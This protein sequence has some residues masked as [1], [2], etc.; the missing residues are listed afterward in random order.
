MDQEIQNQSQIEIENENENEN[1]SQQMS[2]IQRQDPESNL[3]S[4]LNLNKNDSTLQSNTNPAKNN[5]NNN[6]TQQNKQKRRT[7]NDNNDR[8]Y[9]CGCGKSYLSYPALYTHL[10]QKH[11]GKPPEGTVL[12]QNIQKQAAVKGNKSDLIENI[13]SYEAKFINPY[14]A[15][16]LDEFLQ[17]LDTINPS[18]RKDK[19]L[20]QYDNTDPIYVTLKKIW[21]E[22]YNFD[23]FKNEEIS[24]IIQW[25]TLY[26]HI[27]EQLDEYIDQE[28]KKNSEEKKD[29][30]TNQE[31]EKDIIKE[32][33]KKQE[34]SETQ[35]QIKNEQQEQ[36]NQA[37]LNKLQELKEEPVN[38]I[39]SKYLI[40]LSKILSQAGMIEMIFFF[41]LVRKNLNEQG[42]LAIGEEHNF[43]MQSSMLKSQISESN[44]T[45]QQNQNK[46]EF[47][48]QN[49]GDNIVIICNDF[50]IEL[51]PN[52]LR[53]ELAD[54]QVYSFQIIGFQEKKITNAIFCFHYF[55]DW[56]FINKYTNTKLIFK[57][58]ADKNE[59]QQEQQ[60]KQLNK[61]NQ[62][63]TDL[64]SSQIN[65]KSNYMQQKEESESQLQ[66]E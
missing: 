41:C 24:N 57:I 56:L 18:F 23:I 34:P 10:K 44:V 61:Q 55:A 60:S 54:E 40:E 64:Q 25:K 38:K 26:Q 46:P 9:Y 4:N 45:N 2:Q 27:L 5:T 59:L 7:R 12:P 51:L 50:L 20:D 8:N 16:I 43:D 15:N 14:D 58:D 21:L 37:A 19:V 52:Q 48:S 31:T 28:N 22:N 65:E 42:Y 13:N 6:Q 35:T 66:Q 3:N 11:E 53:Q 47:C 29:S 32:E 33:T 49:Q 1:E 36:K 17:F 62:S 30:Q 39:I 63:M